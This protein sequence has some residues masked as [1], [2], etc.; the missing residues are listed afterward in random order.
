M[1]RLGFTV[2]ALILAVSASATDV[3]LTW[4]ANTEP[5]LDGY[6]IYYGTAPGTYGAPL[7]V[8]VMESPESL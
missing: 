8:P 3:T 1:K 5:D 7:P 6:K 4:T 2:L